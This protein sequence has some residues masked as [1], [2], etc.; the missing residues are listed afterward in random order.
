METKSMESAAAEL[1]TTLNEAIKAGVDNLPGAGTLVL[2]SLS[3]Y[4]TGVIMS[5]VI[6]LVLF[7]V[8]IGV[9]VAI[10]FKALVMADDDWGVMIFFVGLITIII[11]SVVT[12]TTIINIAYTF[13]KVFSPLGHIISKSL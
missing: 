3:Q 11:S 13:P 12:I 8:L 10:C 5:S 9:G 1:M 6:F 4:Y 2:E 7:L